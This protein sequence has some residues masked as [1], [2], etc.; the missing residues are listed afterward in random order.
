[1]SGSSGIPDGSATRTIIVDHVTVA[2][3]TVGL[4]LGFTIQ[5]LP[6]LPFGA[7]IK[8]GTSIAGTQLTVNGNAIATGAIGSDFAQA[9]YPICLP[10]AYANTTNKWKPGVAQADP[11]NST[12][13]R[14]VTQAF[15]LTYTGIQVQAAGIITVNPSPIS[16]ESPRLVNKTITTIAGIDGTGSSYVNT[17]PAD[18][19]LMADL[20]AMNPGTTVTPGAAVFRPEAGANGVIKCGSPTYEFS[21]VLDVPC[22]VFNPQSAANNA[23]FATDGASA[24][25]TNTFGS[26]I[27]YDN[28]YQS[29]SINVSGSQSTSNSYRFE[30]IQCMQYKVQTQSSFAFMAKPSP[31][32]DQ[33]TLHVANLALQ[34]TPIATVNNGSS[35]SPYLSAAIAIGKTVAPM[36]ATAIGG[37]S[38]GAV[39]TA[40]AGAF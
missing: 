24:A 29:V 34:N 39:T 8:P 11:Y 25:V 40:V 10:A 31:N 14:M 16:F 23:L 21:D 3:I 13:A 17:G 20:S 27:W 9:W 38:A 6:C 19:V 15:R 36:V 7:V 22:Q 26:V 35:T 30:M 37:P 28:N 5:T 12:Q 32:E 2:D 33:R 4:G 18:P 1:M